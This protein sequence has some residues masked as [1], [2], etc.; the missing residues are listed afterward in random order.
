MP[1]END[2]NRYKDLKEQ[3]ERE[4]LE[5]RVEA[6][7]L[8]LK[9]EARLQQ[10]EKEESSLRKEATIEA[11]LNEAKEETPTE[12][13]LKRLEQEFQNIAESKDG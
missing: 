2:L 3:I 11:Q 13:Q 7:N 1:S 4:E 6:K 5:R 10:Q 12:A 8:L 9:A